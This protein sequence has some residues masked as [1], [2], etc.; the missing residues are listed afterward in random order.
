[1]KS[2]LTIFIRDLWLVFPEPPHLVTFPRIAFPGLVQET[3][4]WFGSRLL[5]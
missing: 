2:T 4:V 5:W 3:Q 1:M